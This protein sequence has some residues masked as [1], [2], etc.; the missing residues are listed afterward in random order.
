MG[1]NCL[2]YKQQLKIAGKW[3][4]KEKLA[5]VWGTQY[6]T[7]IYAHIEKHAKTNLGTLFTGRS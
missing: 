4:A 3:Q 1:C 5:C 6:A 7:M 2:G